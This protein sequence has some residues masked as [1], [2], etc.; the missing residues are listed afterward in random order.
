MDDK[1][2]W[3]GGF[4]RDRRRDGLPLEEDHI[5]SEIDSVFHSPR[6]ILSFL[7]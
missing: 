7:R 5:V 2:D 4:I 6:S 1:G 3:F